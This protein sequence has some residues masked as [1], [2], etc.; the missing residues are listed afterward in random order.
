MKDLEAAENYALTPPEPEAD[1]FE[2]M[3]EHEFMA[4]CY[5]YIMTNE[6]VYDDMIAWYLAECRK[7]RRNDY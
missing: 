4:E 7:G 3:G 6:R 2:E 5:N 1:P